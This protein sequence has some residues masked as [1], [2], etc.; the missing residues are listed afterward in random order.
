MDNQITRL[1]RVEEKI[2]KVSEAIISIARMEEKM[3]TLFNRMDSYDQKQTKM[4]DRLGTVEI[5]V[6]S[7]AWIEKLIFLVVG[8]VV[9]YLIK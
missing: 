3:V 9:A 5:K 2:D 6:A 1:I 4:D 8:A 7:G